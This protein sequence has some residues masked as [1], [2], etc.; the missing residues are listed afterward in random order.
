MLTAWVTVPAITSSIRLALADG[1]AYRVDND[2]D[3]AL[4][5]GHGLLLETKLSMGSYTQFTIWV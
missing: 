3:T 5:V 1:G 4:I 2:R